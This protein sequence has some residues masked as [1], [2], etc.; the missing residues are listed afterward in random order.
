L[1]NLPYAKDIYGD[2]AIYFTLNNEESLIKAI[3][4]IQDK[5]D[6]YKVLVKKRKY[7]IITNRTSWARHWEFFLNN[8]LSTSK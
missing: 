4:L 2:S 6:Y 5:F 8:N 3:E 7:E 1:P